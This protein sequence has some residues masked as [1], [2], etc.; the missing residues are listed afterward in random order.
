MSF[1]VVKL[2]GKQSNNKF[3]QIKPLTKKWPDSLIN[4]TR[5]KKVIV[6]R[7]HIGH[8]RLTH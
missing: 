7:M 2:M 4:R 5:H 8:T 3:N 1:R 6:T